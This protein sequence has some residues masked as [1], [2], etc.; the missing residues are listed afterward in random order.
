MVVVVSRDVHPGKKAIASHGASGALQGEK[1]RDNLILGV[2][3]EEVPL[4]EDRFLRRAF[5]VFL[6]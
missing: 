1:T 2:R 5:C 6:Q 3:P 4:P